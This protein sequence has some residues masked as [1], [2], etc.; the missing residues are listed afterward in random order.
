M[1]SFSPKELS[2]LRRVQQS[3]MM[4]R[5]SLQRASAPGAKNG[6]GNPTVVYADPVTFICGYQPS[7]S[8]EVM[9]GNE[10]VVANAV[11]RLPI[12][13]RP[14]S[15]DRITVTHLKGEEQDP[16]LRFEVVGQ[17]AQ[18]PSGYVVAVQRITY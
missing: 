15:R 14:T 17:P 1:R 16:V 13:A 6:F 7:A 9:I 11:I 10:T 8:N 4:D 2:N 3:A 5:C 12:S 18:G